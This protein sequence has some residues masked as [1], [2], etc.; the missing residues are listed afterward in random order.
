VRVVLDTNILVRALIRRDSVPGRILEAWF[1]D[2][3][4]LLVHP[5]SARRAARRHAAAADPRPGPT[6]GDRAAR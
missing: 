4:I 5:L 3:F 6:V 2:R 1:E